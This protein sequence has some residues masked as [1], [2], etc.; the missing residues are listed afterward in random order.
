MSAPPCGCEHKHC[1][2]HNSAGS[3]ATLVQPAVRS[4]LVACLTQRRLASSRVQHR[5]T[6]TKHYTNNSLLTRTRSDRGSSSTLP[7][8]QARQRQHYWEPIDLSHT[9]TLCSSAHRAGGQR[10]SDASAGVGAT[11]EPGAQ[12][13]SARTLRAPALPSPRPLL[14]GPRAAL[15]PTPALAASASASVA[16]VL[17]DAGGPG[18]GSARRGGPMVGS[19]SAGRGSAAPACLAPAGCCAA[20]RAG[21]AAAAAADAWL[22]S[23]AL[24]SRARRGCSSGPSRWAAARRSSLEAAAAARGA[25]GPE[26]SRGARPA[27]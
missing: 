3:P 2:L 27:L 7:G 24:P 17:G 14:A 4:D 13:A 11:A 20:P 23:D 25:S 26:P 5:A 6:R 22:G 15:P 21:A 1:A 10:A 8:P 12:G 18:L 16:G 19:G 9:A